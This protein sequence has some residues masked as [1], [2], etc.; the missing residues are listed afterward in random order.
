MELLVH[1]SL[2]F[3][4]MLALCFGNRGK[5]SGDH[6]S[7]VDFPFTGAGTTSR[8]VV[9]ATVPQLCVCPRGDRTLRRD[10]M[11]LPQGW[12]PT[13]GT[14]IPAVSQLE[15]S[16]SSVHLH[17]GTAEAPPGG[18]ADPLCCGW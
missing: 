1:S 8:G 13:S 4:R 10:V 5:L 18:I 3:A 11:A 14:V 7:I 15:Q 6:L 12:G 16:N 2:R 17:L 9:S